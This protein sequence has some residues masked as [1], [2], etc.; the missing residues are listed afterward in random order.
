MG[1]S[2]EEEVVIVVGANSS[3]GDDQCPRL[4]QSPFSHLLT[5]A[6][7]LRLAFYGRTVRSQGL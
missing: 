3:R 1:K 5:S 4:R 7:V 2:T 6:W